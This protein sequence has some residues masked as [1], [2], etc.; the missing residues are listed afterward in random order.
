MLAAV[1]SGSKSHAG[2]AGMQSDSDLEHACVPAS[3]Q[4]CIPLRQLKWLRGLNGARLHRWE[5]PRVLGRHQ[6]Q[7]LLMT[8]LLCLL[9]VLHAYW[10]HLI[11]RIAIDFVRTGEKRDTRE[12]KD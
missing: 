5:L 8:L 10:F 4:T 12:S 3:P 1:V 7:S 11:V 6:Q 9:V 2:Q